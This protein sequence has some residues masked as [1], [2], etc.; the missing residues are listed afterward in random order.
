MQTS[1]TPWKEDVM[2]DETS[3]TK[4]GIKTATFPWNIC[5]TFKLSSF[6]HIKLQ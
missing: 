3:K 2:E 4:T 5:K 1:T 6:G